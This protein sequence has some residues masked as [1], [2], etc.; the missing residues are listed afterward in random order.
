MGLTFLLGDVFTLFQFVIDRCF[1]SRQ[2]SVFQLLAIDKDAGGAAHAGLP[3]VVSIG[4]DASSGLGIVHAGFKS[5][6]VQ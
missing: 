3:S 1:E 5:G 4:A 6:F 2:G